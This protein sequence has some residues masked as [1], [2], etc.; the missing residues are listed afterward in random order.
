MFAGCG[1]NCHRG[2]RTRWS[3]INDLEDIIR[4]HGRPWTRGE[5][6]GSQRSIRLDEEAGLGDT[7]HKQGEY[8]GR[9]TRPPHIHAKSRNFRREEDGRPIQRLFAT[10]CLGAQSKVTTFDSTHRLYDGVESGQ[11]LVMDANLVPQYKFEDW[12]RAL[13]TILT[14]GVQHFQLMRHL[15]S[16]QLYSF[17]YLPEDTRINRPNVGSASPVSPSST[18]GFPMALTWGTRTPPAFHSTLCIGGGGGGTICKLQAILDSFPGLPSR[19]TTFECG[20]TDERDTSRVAECH[21]Q[22]LPRSPGHHPDCSNMGFAREGIF[23][24]PPSPEPLSGWAF[25]ASEKW[26]GV[27][28]MGR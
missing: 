27:R 2:L 12:K 25:E 22:A 14:I 28:F 21:H 13:R 17:Q 11:K 26:G 24:L 6:P 5:V 8:G 16:N 20:R 18:V 9:G 7:R 19:L 10:F 4:C 1:T 15:P 23:P 3:E